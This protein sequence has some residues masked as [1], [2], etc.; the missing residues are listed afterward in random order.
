M[1]IARAAFTE[2]IAMTITQTA[3]ASITRG[4][5]Q[6]MSR[7]MTNSEAITNLNH[8][9]GIVSPDIQRSLDVAIKA[10]EEKPQGD[11]ISRS[12]LKKEFAKF[13][14]IYIADTGNELV[15]AFAVDK[16]IDNAPTVEINDKSLE[17]AQKSIELGRRLGK[18]EGK[19][20]RPQG[21]WQENE[22]GTGFCSKCNDGI[23]YR[24]PTGRVYMMLKEQIVKFGYKY[25]PN[26]GADMR[27]EVENV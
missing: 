9:Y 1:R 26:C 3:L 17:I 15:N 21:E 8:I 20:E 23:Y 6:K 27:E 2:T 13:D 24:T 5:F 25:C 18:L 7:K 10:L 22:N 19:P 12:E 11:L 4:R 14:R 16:L